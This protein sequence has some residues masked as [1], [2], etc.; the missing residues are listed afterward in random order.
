[1]A[2]RLM[3]NFGD[4]CKPVLVEII[5]GIAAFTL[6]YPYNEKELSI[7]SNSVRDAAQLAGDRL[8]LFLVQWHW[9]RFVIDA[10]TGSFGR[11]IALRDG[12]VG[13]VQR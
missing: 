10:W 5:E 3:R 8:Q 11:R 6:L 13:F 12:V 7:P 1:M 4:D 2:R 9:S